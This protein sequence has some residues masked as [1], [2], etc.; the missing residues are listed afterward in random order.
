M[1]TRLPQSNVNLVSIQ[2]PGHAADYDRP[3]GP[4]VVKWDG[5]VGAYLQEKIVR[6]LGQS[7]G[8]KL[9]RVR[10][11]TLIIPGDLSPRI[12]L[13]ENDTVTYRYQDG[14]SKSWLTATRVVQA[15]ATPLAPLPGLPTT[16]RISLTDAPV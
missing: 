7:E 11:S 16:V 2:T 1:S 5:S 14:A 8:G 10:Q 3:P 4:D 12:D 6:N 9:D 13:S 15:I